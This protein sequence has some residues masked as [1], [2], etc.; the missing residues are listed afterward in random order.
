MLASDAFVK[1]EAP[2]DTSIQPTNIAFTAVFGAS[3][4]GSVLMFA[5]AS[6]KLSY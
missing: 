2:P 1:L 3:V 4:N 5:K 6:T